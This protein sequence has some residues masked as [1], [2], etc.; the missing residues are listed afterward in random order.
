MTP[1]TLQTLSE[2]HRTELRRGWRDHWGN[3]QSSSGTTRGRLETGYRLC[4]HNLP[5]FRYWYIFNRIP[6]SHTTPS[7][8]R[9]ACGPLCP[10]HVT[11]KGCAAV[12][13]H[14]RPST[15]PPWDLHL[16]PSGQTGGRINGGWR[17]ES[18]GEQ[19]ISQP[20]R[21]GVH[22]DWAVTSPVNSLCKKVEEVNSSVRISSGHRVRIPRRCC[23][24]FAGSPIFCR[25]NRALPREMKWVRPS[26]ATSVLSAPSCGYSS[27]GIHPL[28]KASNMIPFPQSGTTASVGFKER[29]GG[30][31]E[32]RE[33]SLP[34]P[35][36]LLLKQTAPRIYRQTQNQEHDESLQ[37]A[38]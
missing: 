7:R 18:W 38:G 35:S 37:I 5:I 30:R 3:G 17:C 33:K 12:G 1:Y 28:W 29:E 32:K 2:G 19:S 22:S 23:S 13:P 8:A 36:S 16:H 14:T 10:A 4:R 25:C 15:K 31:K 24:F 26:P 21:R 20:D 27:S 34:A 11:A 6:S 9:K